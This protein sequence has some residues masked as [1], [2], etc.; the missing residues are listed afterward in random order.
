MEAEEEAMNIDL[1]EL[2]QAQIQV[3]LEASPLEP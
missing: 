2:G 1:E 3:S